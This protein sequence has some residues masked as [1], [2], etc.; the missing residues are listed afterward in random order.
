MPSAYPGG[1]APSPFAY[2]GQPLGDIAHDLVSPTNGAAARRP[3]A[4]S[5]I[6]FAPTAGRITQTADVESNRVDYHMFRI[7]AHQL[8]Q[9]SLLCLDLESCWLHYILRLLTNALVGGLIP[10]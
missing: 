8:S 6:R 1:R 5:R 4:L 7:R 9:N 3:G 2:L 10:G